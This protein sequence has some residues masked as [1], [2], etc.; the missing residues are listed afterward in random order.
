MPLF[1]DDKSQDIYDNAK[2]YERVAYD[3][4]Y[5]EHAAAE[6]ECHHFAE[7]IPPSR[8]TFLTG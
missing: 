7:E 8:N 6:A 3:I 2:P 5:R 4:L 1:N